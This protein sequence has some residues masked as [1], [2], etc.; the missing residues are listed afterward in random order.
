MRTI[1]NEN[2]FSVQYDRNP[3]MT[4]KDSKPTLFYQTKMFLT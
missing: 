2:N 4:A 1:E 3:L